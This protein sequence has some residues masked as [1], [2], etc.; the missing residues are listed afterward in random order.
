V[1]QPAFVSTRFENIGRV[2]NR[3]FEATIDAE[4]VNQQSR[5]LSGGLILSVERNSVVDLGGRQFIATASV[6][7]QGQSGQ[8][9][10]RIMPGHPLGTFWGPEFVGVDAQGKQLFNKYTVTRDANGV[11]TGRTLAGTSTSPSGD[12]F[13]VIGNANPDFSLGVRNNATW[14][15]FDASWLWRGE[16]GRDVFNNTALVYSTK[17]NALQD[18]NFLKSALDD[19][20]GI[21]EPAIYSSR[22]IE[23]GRFVRLQNITLGYRFDLPTR[24]R[25]GHDTRLYVSGDN[26]LL[27]TP[28][29]GYDPEVH[30]DAGLATRGIDYLVYPRARTF[31][32]G[33]RIQF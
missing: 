5:S 29:S 8:N 2:R 30:T 16:F 19:P 31:T 7:G 25:V 13:T 10:Q 1:P 11:E 14:K 26:L 4:L 28:Y 20:T 18:K 12:D 3:G 21:R 6:S 23:N 32:F 33:G 22:W 15:Q 9:A 27:F 17:G 24:L